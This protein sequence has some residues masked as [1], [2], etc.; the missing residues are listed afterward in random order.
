MNALDMELYE[1]ALR[2][3]ADTKIAQRRKVHPIAINEAG[4]AR[5]NAHEPFSG[6]GWGDLQRGE[7]RH[8]WST[9]NASTLMV[10]RGYSEK[11]RGFLA[12][13]RFVA[14]SQSDKLSLFLNG[15]RV[16]L[17]RI[18]EK[19][20][21]GHRFSFEVP[22]SSDKELELRFELDPLMSFSNVDKNS[23]D[24]TPL[25]FALVGLGFDPVD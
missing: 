15:E 22:P 9:Q 24:T 13:D 7:P 19:G 18:Q 23:K 16:K 3:I 25:G 2:K 11:M 20:Q 14:S 10:A 17:D 6:T 4:F 1:H 8:R 21:K 5:W 12:I